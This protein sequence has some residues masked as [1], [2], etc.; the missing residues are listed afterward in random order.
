M[1]DDLATD[2]QPEPRAVRL[3]GERVGDLAELLEHGRLLR[4]LEAGAVVGHVDAHG[5]A[6]H[7]GV[8]ADTAVRAVAELHGVRQ[9]VD[10]D[11]HEAVAIGVDRGQRLGQIDIEANRALGTQPAGRGERLLDH[12]LGVDLGHPPLHAA[13]LHLGEVE[14]HVDQA[15]KALALLD[16]DAEELLALRGAH[17][18]VVVKDFAERAHRCKRRAELVAD[19]RDEVVLET[20]ELLELLVGGAQLAARRLELARLLLE[21]AAVLDHLRRLVED[22]HHLVEARRLL[23]HDRGDHHP[24]RGRADGARELALGELHEFGVGV[25]GD[26]EVETAAARV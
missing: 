16:D 8:H 12:L 11:L 6:R 22:R 15:R 21:P 10:D 9:Q 26:G 3:V 19:R 4:G 17:A 20:V 23:L 5:L 14:D 13:R 18:R 2:R 1:L 24:R 25:G 7:R